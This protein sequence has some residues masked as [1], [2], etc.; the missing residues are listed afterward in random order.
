MCIKLNYKWF[1]GFKIKKNNFYR[2]FQKQNSKTFVICFDKQ[3]VIIQI[4][5]RN[6]TF[7]KNKI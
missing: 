2:L 1:M 7:T 6:K 5:N 4:L 3:Y